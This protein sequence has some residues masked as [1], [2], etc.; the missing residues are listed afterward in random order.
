MKIFI[1]C[2]AF[3][4]L[5]M[6]CTSKEAYLNKEYERVSN[7]IDGLQNELKATVNAQN[8]AEDYAKAQA[9]YNLK[10]Q[11]LTEVR[12]ANSGKGLPLGPSF[13]PNVQPEE[14]V[15]N[16]KKNFDT[17]SDTIAELKKKKGKI[18]EEQMKIGK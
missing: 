16:L 7:E 9:A 11:K 15:K 8:T 18:V 6:G 3:V 2:L 14:A 10:V 5:F 4:F 12:N 13:D 17:L 1:Y